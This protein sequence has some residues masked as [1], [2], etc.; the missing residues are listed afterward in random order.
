MQ[1][2]K[3]MSS[4]GLALVAAIM[5]FGFIRR[6]PE[7]TALATIL[8]KGHLAGSTYVQQP[9][10]ANR[11][12]NT[13]NTIQIAEANAFDLKVDGVDQAVRASFNT[14]KSRQFDVGQRVRVQFVRRGLPPLWSRLTVVEMMPVDAP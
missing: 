5:W 2:A 9:I 3:L 6:G 11:G 13:P 1:T 12:F 4:I 8:T 10:G 7:Q 14:V